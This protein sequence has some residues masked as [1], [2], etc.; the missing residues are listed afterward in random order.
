MV[1]LMAR[2]V[3]RCEQLGLPV[4]GG[5]TEQMT[6]VVLIDE[7]DLHLHPTWQ[8]RVISDV[9]AVFPRLTFVITTH[10]PMTLMGARE[11]EIWRLN[12]ASDGA[13]AAQPIDLPPGIR[14]DQILTGPWFGL[15]SALDHE[16]ASKLDAYRNMLAHG[17]QAESPERQELEAELRATLGAFADTWEERVA[18]EWRRQQVRVSTPEQKAKLQE[19][20]RERLEILRR[21]REAKG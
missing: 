5:F 20:T 16:T 11:G 6:G 7:I 19:R 8:R 1:D 10:H 4:R 12:P 13:L 2:W 15:P 21:A 3:T 14:V 17:V 9:R 18:A